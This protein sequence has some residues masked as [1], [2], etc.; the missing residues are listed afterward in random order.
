MKL[1]VHT[2]ILIAIV[3][4]VVAGIVLGERVAHIKI[5]GDIFIRLLKAIIIP[6]ILAS[7]VEKEAAAAEERGL[8]A[9]VFLNRLRDPSFRPKLLQSDPTAIYGCLVMPQRIAACD[10]FAGHATPALNRDPNNAYSTYVTV[11]LPLGPIANPGEASVLAV[12]APPTTKY[13][14]FVAA[15][16][17]AH[18]V[19]PTSYELD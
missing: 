8:I 11:G 14:Y 10:D 13:Q 9:S 5:V 16:D 19:T 7:M 4:A 17:G 15:G 3:L 2:Q 1:K 6:L 12:L 18:H